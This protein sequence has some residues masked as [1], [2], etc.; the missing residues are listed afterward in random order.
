[1]K[2]KKGD[3]ISIISGKDRAKTG[4][5]I[6]A[7]PKEGKITV[8]NINLKKKHAKPKKQGEKGQVIEIPAPFSI[9]NA[10]LICPKCGKPTRVGYKIIEKKKYRACKKC[11]QEI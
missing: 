7:F 6:S 3:T 4:K 2:I 10:Q 5:V 11:E 1:M 8:E 9:S